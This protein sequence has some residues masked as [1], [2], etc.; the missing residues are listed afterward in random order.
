MGKERAMGDAKQPVRSL[1]MMQ[2][3][4]NWENEKNAAKGNNGFRKKKHK[5]TSVP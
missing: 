3:R 4:K 5:L 1:D 2:V